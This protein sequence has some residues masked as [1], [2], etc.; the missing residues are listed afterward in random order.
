M[1]N[2]VKE[3]KQEE[4]CKFI[5]YFY[6]LFCMEDVCQKIL[7]HVG[8][9]LDT[10]PGQMIPREVLLSE[11][12]YNEIKDKIPELK[13]YFSSSV[14]TSLQGNADKQQRWPLLNLVRQILH[15]HKIEMKPLRKSDGYTKEG[16]KKYKRYFVLNSYSGD[17]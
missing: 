3:T 7:E 5:H 17:K 6:F 8:I 15:S 10:L 14:L 4:V 12:K 2:I 1:E 13:Q 16:V 9:T 11:T